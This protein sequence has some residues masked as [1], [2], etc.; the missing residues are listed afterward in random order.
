MRSSHHGPWPNGGLAR[1]GLGGASTTAEGG[2]FGQTLLTTRLTLQG[3]VLVESAVGCFDKI[4]HFTLI[5][6]IV[7]WST[8]STDRGI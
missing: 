8:V 1:L 3:N 5:F 7:A 6:D 4:E 2:E